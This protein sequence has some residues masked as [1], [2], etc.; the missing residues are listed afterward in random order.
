M[1]KCL[2]CEGKMEIIRD[3]IYHYTESGLDNVYLHGIVQYRCESCGEMAAEIPKIKALHR[4]IARDIICKREALSGDEVRF[5]RKE[6]A[7][8]SKDMAETLA[9]LPETYSRWENGK[10]SVGPSYDRQLRLIYILNA[11]EEDGKVIH[12]NIR[13]MLSKMAVLPQSS[14]KIDIAPQ[15][16][17]LDANEPAFSDACLVG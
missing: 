1:E 5:L 8:K 4:V 12:K 6:I 9:I 11:S 10:Q 16:W 14:T 3:E 2:K 7:M 17:M 15:E 13:K